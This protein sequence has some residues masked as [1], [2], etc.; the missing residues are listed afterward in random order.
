VLVYARYDCLLIR[1]ILSCCVFGAVMV[2]CAVISVIGAAVT[3]Y[4]I[5]SQRRRREL[6]V[7]KENESEDAD[8]IVQ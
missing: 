6:S 2:F 5:P 8:S 7:Y 1:L 3:Q 4:D